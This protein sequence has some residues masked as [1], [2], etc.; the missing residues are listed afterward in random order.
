SDP[1][2]PLFCPGGRRAR[3]QTRLKII[4]LITEIDNAFLLLKS[5]MTGHAMIYCRKPRIFDL[6]MRRITRF[7]ASSSG[8]GGKHKDPLHPLTPA[9]YLFPNLLD[10]A[11]APDRMIP[12][13]PRPHHGFSE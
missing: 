7:S 5:Q 2:F 4:R 13:V 9:T 12:L 3:R 10:P 11:L 8:P 1:T 6:L